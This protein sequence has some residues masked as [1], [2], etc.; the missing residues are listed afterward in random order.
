M[1]S[2]GGRIRAASGASIS[3]TATGVPYTQ[4]FN[5]LASSGSSSTLPTGWAFIESGANA[6]TTYTAGSGSITTGDTY[7]FGASGSSERALGGLQSGN[8][9]PIVGAC[10]TNNTGGTINALAFAYTGEQWR[11]GAS[12]RGA[13]RLDFQ[14]STNATSLTTGTWIDYDS[15]DFSSP[16]ATGTVGALN[17]NTAVN[18]S[19]LSFTINGLNIVN[20]QTFFIR[21]LDFNVANSDD[22]LAIDDFSL[23][24]DGN[25]GGNGNPSGVGSANPSTLNPGG[26]T[27]LTVQAMPGT[28]PPSSGL[29]VAADL[30]T[31]GGA[32][33]QDL[34]DDSTHGDLTAGD[35]I[36]SFQATVAA[37]TS[38]GNKSLP[39]TISDA[40]GRTGTTAIFLSVVTAGGACARCG[41]ERW[42]VKTGTD[43][44]AALI[45]TAHPMATT[46]A[47]MRSW[48]SQLSPPSNSR[49]APYEMTAWTVEATLTLYKKEDDSDYHLVLQDAAGNTLVSEIPCPGCVGSGCPFAS[50]I[51]NARVTF[52]A[53]LTATGSFQTANLPVRVTGVGMFDFPH[54]QT[55][56][57]PNQIELHPIIDIDFEPNCTLGVSNPY[58]FARATGAQATVNVTASGPC[59]W[60]AT[61]N[62]NWITIT[63]AASGI[64]NGSVTYVVRDNFTG[65]AR[66][67]TMTIASQTVT[68]TQDGGP[69]SD[70][71]YSI[72][73]PA[74][75]FGSAAGSSTLLIAVSERCS[76][77]A[78]AN[79]P[80]ITITSS[81]N[82]IG[83]GSVTFSVA[84]NSGSLSRKGAIT[85]G[86]EVF[87]VK[88]KGA[89]TS[90]AI[91]RRLNQSPPRK[92]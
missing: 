31:I 13:D 20:G 89:P 54:G 79:V 51:S 82:G 50:M 10:F 26:A 76:W 72:S 45:D 64:G 4:D 63:S 33:N 92:I 2:P 47:I 3:L 68:V 71:Q 48:P 80:W 70:C 85:I 75:V 81:P 14:L 49:I 61:S 52:D 53:R 18:R 60:T 12:G 21:W 43:P 91:P 37:A 83:N 38:T 15:L 74:Q 57:A 32:A 5:T 34:F 44:A 29:A 11:L 67:G 88:Q 30:T 42:S 86:S 65:S 16:V 40:Q 7:S 56:A 23:T 73:P 6:N 78:A 24:P 46:I 17:G 1:S 36:F 59:S 87:N 8:L 28:N 66:Q 41:V 25:G 27:L 62:A 35:N 55:G 39:V 69:G 90:A 9:V 84:T 77:R 19:R 58:P 22:G